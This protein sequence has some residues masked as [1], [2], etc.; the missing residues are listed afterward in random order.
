MA[1]TIIGIIGDFNPEN[2]THL[3]TNEGIQHAAEVFGKP[4]E[5]VWL[6]TDQ[7][8]EYKEFD[9]LVG[10]PGSPYRSFDGALAGIRYARE[11]EIPFIGT[12]GGSQ[13]LMIEYARNV[14]GLVDAAHAETD[15]YASCLFVTPLSCS[16]VGKT[17]EVI[18]RSGSKA[19]AA[20]QAERSMEAFYC[21]FGLNPAY[22]EHLESAG[23][24]ITGKDENGEARIVEL[25]SHPFFVGTLFVPQARS[26]PGD[27]HPLFL[28]F[29]RAAASQN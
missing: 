8:A 20:Y 22:Q 24:E 14:M 25:N 17:M 10:S 9:G 4:I 26:K 18:I 15:P 5:A 23:L 21:N 16:L 3:A 13:H 29:C 7:P 1:T 27:P 2:T 19:A 12:C 28:E 11:N 6:A